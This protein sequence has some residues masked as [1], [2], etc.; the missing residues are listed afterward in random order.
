MMGWA[1][2]GKSDGLLY[3]LYMRVN[4]EAIHWD[5]PI[6]NCVKL[7]LVLAVM[8]SFVSFHCAMVVCI[9]TALK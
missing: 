8:A 6:S 5:K 3:Q 7:K 1:H 4:Y 2:K 9:N